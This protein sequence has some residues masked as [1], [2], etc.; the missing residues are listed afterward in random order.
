MR[1]LWAHD[2]EDGAGRAFDVL[3]QGLPEV[4]R[5]R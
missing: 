1:A 3:V 4:A 5:G 2:I